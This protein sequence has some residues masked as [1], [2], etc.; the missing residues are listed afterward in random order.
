M[1]KEAKA[2]SSNGME[3]ACKSLYLHTITVENPDAEKRAE[4]RNFLKGETSFDYRKIIELLDEK[5]QKDAQFGVFEFNGY[6]GEVTEDSNSL[7][8]VFMTPP[9]EIIPKMTVALIKR[10]LGTPI[11]WTVADIDPYLLTMYRQFNKRGAVKV[12]ENIAKTEPAISCLRRVCEEVSRMASSEGHT[13][14]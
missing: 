12:I 6:I 14:Q 4:V 9:F 7:T 1:R 5:D 10:F 11:R 13:V 2:V 3:M 8:Y